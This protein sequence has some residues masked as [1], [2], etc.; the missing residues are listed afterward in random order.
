MLLHS[1]TAD[2]LPSG[3]RNH[4]NH[5][6]NRPSP[7]P[8]INSTEMSKSCFPPSNKIKCLCVVSPPQLVVSLFSAVTVPLML[9]LWPRLILSL[10]LSMPGE[11]S[12]MDWEHD[13]KVFSQPCGDQS[14]GKDRSHFNTLSWVFN[15]KSAKQSKLQAEMGIIIIIIISTFPS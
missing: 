9:A 6:D 13:W 2:V 15:C 14:Q 11:A 5:L 7:A 10:V 4:W 8:T 3:L 1:N 12:H